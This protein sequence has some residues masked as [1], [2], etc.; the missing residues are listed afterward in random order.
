MSQP[1]ITDNTTLTELQ[2]LGATTLSDIPI[3]ELLEYTRHIC[4]SIAADNKA[5]SEMGWGNNF[6]KA[7]IQIQGAI[8]SI[9]VAIPRVDPE[10]PYTPTII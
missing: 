7:A 3:A 9:D 10:L 6:T 5:D 2:A 1:I 4:L 8:E